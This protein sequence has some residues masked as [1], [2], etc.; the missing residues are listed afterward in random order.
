M[1]LLDKSGKFKS[2]LTFKTECIL[3][4]L[5]YFQW[6]QLTEA[7]P[8]AWKNIFQNNINNNGS[9]I[10]KDHDIIR[11]TLIVSINKLAWR[12]FH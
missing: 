8:K 3:R 6:L 2:W 9:L 11:R 1:N 7:I 4:S 5:F 10:I 12:D